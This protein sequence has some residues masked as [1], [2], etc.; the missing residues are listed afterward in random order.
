M[1]IA[2]LMPDFLQLHL[3]SDAKRASLTASSS[4]PSFYNL[5]L[6]RLQQQL[7]QQSRYQS[8]VN[9]M[10]LAIH[11]GVELGQI[12]QQ[13]IAGISQVLE[14]ERGVILLF[15]YTDFAYRSRMENRTPEASV[16]LANEWPNP[17][18]TAPFS[19]PLSSSTIGEELDHTTHLQ[20]DSYGSFW[21][22]EC[23]LCQHL[24]AQAP[25]YLILHQDETNSLWTGMATLLHPERWSS[26]LVLPLTSRGTVLG[27]MVLQQSRTGYVWATEAVELA[28][29]ISAQI[30]TAIIQTQTL[31]Q[32]QALV[33]ERTAQLHRSLEVQ[34]RLY[35]TT[36]QQ[37]EQLRQSN[38]LKDEF[39]STI[40]HELRTP[41]T[42]MTLAIRM[43]RQAE[44][45]P[46]RRM[47]YLDILEQQCNQ[48]SN[49]INDLLT[50]QKLQSN[51]EPLLFQSL[52]LKQLIRD[53][54]TRFEHNYATK[55]LTL[56]LNLPRRSLLMESNADSIQRILE[57]L[58]TNA[59]KYGD[60]H[61]TVQL[62]VTSQ[63]TEAAESANGKAHIVIQVTNVGLGIPPEEMPY[64]FDQFHRGQGV[65]Q[66]AIPGTGLGLTLIKFMTQHLQGTITAT[67]HPLDQSENQGDNHSQSWETCFTLVLPQR[68]NQP[69]L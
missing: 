19:H 18:T 56:E 34:S 1:V 68:P 27:V 9:E 23:T 47:R 36:R 65:T 59:G 28:S 43:L 8:L 58:L 45:P 50:M 31:R 7:H 64:I 69:T 17:S 13:A 63:D 33:K 25:P 20:P 4:L 6:D 2:P 15:K 16:R 10:I 49:L 14:V 40:S 29:L 39:L 11:G 3:P 67:S 12:L 26:M 22:S 61:S 32:V 54:A 5:A 35:E 57:E 46:D 51:P 48:E 30:S 41:L 52:D 42:S 37:M 24:V 44:L 53:L 55:G 21:L 38:Q 62:Q 60:R 66:Q